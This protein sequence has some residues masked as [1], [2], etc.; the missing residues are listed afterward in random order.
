[1][2]SELRKTRVVSKI[3]KRNA[4]VKYKGNEININKEDDKDMEKSKTS[5][6]AVGIALG[7]AFGLATDNIGVGI[8]LGVAIGASVD[9]SKKKSSKKKNE[10]EL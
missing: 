2:V 5:Y 7:V 3:K 1:M 10:E 6:L 9:A 8:A 4:L